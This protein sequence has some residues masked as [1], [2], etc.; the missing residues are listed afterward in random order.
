MLPR[1]DAIWDRRLPIQ[2][3]SRFKTHGHFLYDWVY[4]HIQAHA[5]EFR[6]AGKG[7]D[8]WSSRQGKLVRWSWD[9]FVP[10]LVRAVR[11]SA[12]GLMEV[13]E[14]P[15]EKDVVVTHDG[16]MP[17]ELPQLATFLSFAMIADAERLCDGTWW[18]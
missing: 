9:S 7:I 14:K 16:E 4:D 15:D 2:L 6:V 13:F 18:E 5:Y 17:P 12:H 10:E 11:N 3:R 8:V 1:L